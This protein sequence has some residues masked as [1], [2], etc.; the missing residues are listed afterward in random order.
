MCV[1]EQ[2]GDVPLSFLVSS[3]IGRGNTSIILFVIT[4]QPASGYHYDSYTN[5]C[6]Q[7]MFLAL[8]LQGMI[9]F[10]FFLKIGI[11]IRVSGMVH[12]GPPSVFSKHL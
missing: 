11:K 5:F 2:T 3:H 8:K 9:F 4:Y 10:L 6:G 12:Y 1:C 7:Q